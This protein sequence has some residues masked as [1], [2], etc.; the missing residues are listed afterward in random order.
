M[1]DPFTTNLAILVLICLTL[2]YL[3][4][5]S[6]E[7]LFTFDVVW[8]NFRAASLEVQIK[9]QIKSHRYTNSSP[10]ATH[11]CVLL[12]IGFEGLTRWSFSADCNPR[13]IVAKKGDFCFCQKNGRQSGKGIQFSK[14]NLSKQ[15]RYCIKKII[16]L[17]YSFI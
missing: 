7:F 8:F 16:D 11:E 9:M 5:F 6:F 14:H 3:C 12:L 17:F 1:P 10:T 2:M 4:Y 15:L 13:L